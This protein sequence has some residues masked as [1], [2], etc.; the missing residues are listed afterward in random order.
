MERLATLLESVRK[1]RMDRVNLIHNLITFKVNF[2]DE[3]PFAV[4]KY[5]LQLTLIELLKKDYTNDESLITFEKETRDLLEFHLLK[6]LE[7]K[8]KCCVSGC[9]FKT[10]QHRSYIRH[11]QHSHSNALVFSCQFGKRCS[12][13]F[14]SIEL[15]ISHIDHTHKKV[16]ESCGSLEKK[17]VSPIDTSCKCMLMK[18]AGRQFSNVRQFM[19]HLRNDHRGEV[20]G[21]I[22]SGCEKQFENSDTLRKHFYLK[23]V[24]INSMSLKAVYLVNPTPAM[25]LAENVAVD[26]SVYRNYDMNMVDGTRDSDDCLDEE[27]EVIND[28]EKL[29]KMSFCDFLNRLTNVQFVPQSTVLIVANEYLKQYTRSNAVK[30]ERIKALLIQ[31][32]VPDPDR[33]RIIAA[34]AENDEFLDAQTSLISEHKRMQYISDNFTYIPPEEIVLNGEDVK[35]NKARKDVIHYVSVVDSLRNLLQDST[36]VAL[37]ANNVVP[38]S[39]SLRDVKDGDLFKYNTFFRDNPGAYSMLMYSDAIELVNPLGAGRGRHKVIQIFYSLGEIPLHLRSKIDR[40]QLVA[41]FKEKLLKKYGFKIIYQRLIA[42]LLKLEE[43]IEIQY[44]VNRVVKCGLLMHPCDNL[45]AHSVGGFSQSFSAKDICRF[46][47]IQHDDLIDNIH[48]YGSRPHRKWTVSEYDKAA[49]AA[50]EELQTVTT[51]SMREKC[52][53]FLELDDGDNSDVMIASDN[54]DE[55]S[56][57][58][59]SENHNLSENDLPSRYGVKHDCPLNKLSAFHSTSG[60]PPD[61]LHDLYE[62]ILLWF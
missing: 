18:C 47:H 30:L 58:I 22:F 9:L 3:E 45:E 61:L 19:L 43:G 37:E 50:E 24:K 59:D 55:E 23:H 16:S 42:D 27:D 26:D 8:I 36:F 53:N 12:R 54:S 31:S 10:S 44:P 60:F 6:P 51:V 32:N 5:R 11:L 14:D 29:F 48:N 49:K 56:T 41:V 17:K 20:V 38:D 40:I 25:E 57:D 2:D 39:D 46:C 35:L 1:N 34:V 62:G 21:C 52:A 4:L 28:Y 33:E 13:T 7:D 15:L